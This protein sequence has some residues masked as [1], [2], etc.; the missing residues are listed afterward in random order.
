VLSRLHRRGGCH[1]LSA[2]YD[3]GMTERIDAFLARLEQLSIDD[4]QVLSLPRADPDARDELLDRVDAAARAAGRL[5]ELDDAADRARAVIVNE[6]SFRGLEPT[7]FGLNW[8]RALARSED[9]A[10]LVEAVEDAAIAAV[11]A[12][13][14]PEEAAALAER[15]ELVASM[16][17]AAPATNPSSATHR[18]VVRAAWL[19]GAAGLLLGAGIVLTQLVVDLLGRPPCPPD[20]L[21]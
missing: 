17:G 12:D 4:L 16:A 5:D 7:W 19:V 2:R 11:V 15:F 21:C 1:G 20:M 8:G 13:L 3:P 10:T 18:N 6:L 14:V 9:R